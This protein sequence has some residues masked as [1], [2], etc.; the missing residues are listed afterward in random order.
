[1]DNTTLRPVRTSAAL[2]V[3]E[4]LLFMKSGALPD[5]KGV[6]VGTGVMAG[7]AVGAGVAAEATKRRDGRERWREFVKLLRTCCNASSRRPLYDHLTR[8]R[9]IECEDGTVALGERACI[10]NC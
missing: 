2:I 6:G 7:A 3:L 5:T 9:V 10:F 8:R 1:M 4:R